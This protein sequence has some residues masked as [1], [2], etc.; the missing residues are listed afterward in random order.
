ML[1]ALNPSTQ[2]AEAKLTEIRLALNSQNTTCLC[3]QSTGLKSS[4]TMPSK[5]VFSGYPSRITFLH[6]IHSTKY[7]ILPDSFFPSEGKKTLLFLYPFS[8]Y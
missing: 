1:H 2:E 3:L 5:S 4:T 7:P 8:N 6:W